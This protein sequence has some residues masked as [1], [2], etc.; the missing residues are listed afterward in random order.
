MKSVYLAG[1]DV[2]RAD[3]GEVA[4]AHKALCR[5]CG[6]EPL[7]PGDQPPDA[8]SRDIFH[9]NIGM[10]RRADA[11]LAN[12]EPFRGPEVDSGTA[13]EV[14]FAVALGKLV[15]GHVAIPESLRQRVA[16]LY[17][18][19]AYHPASGVWRDRDGQLVED[20]GHAVNLMLAESCAAIVG[21]GVA[22]AL[23]WLCA[24]HGLTNEEIIAPAPDRI[25][26]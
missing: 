17:G 7:H 23:A 14:G 11:V 3:A 2:F 6:F 19:V 16:R 18:E 20:F 12:L 13:F 22:G 5:R 4:L 25:C 24:R 26:A 15:V 1:P 8:T 9:A 10:I 21:G